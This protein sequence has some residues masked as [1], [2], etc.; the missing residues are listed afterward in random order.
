LPLV[1]IR[2]D[3]LVDKHAIAQLPRAFLKRQCDQISESALGHGVLIGEEPVVGVET[4]FMPRFCSPG[5]EGGA[6]PA[7]IRGWYCAIKEEP[8]VAAVARPGSFQRSR[9]A[10]TAAGFQEGGGVL[11]P[12]RFVK[13]D[14][15]KPTGLVRQQ[16]VDPDSGPPLKVVAN[17]L[18]GQH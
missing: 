7:S 16:R 1:R 4:D 13:I 6:Q 18:V 15:E 10:V 8:D 5:E 11:S 9:H 12:S 3:R 2:L 17:R 14:G